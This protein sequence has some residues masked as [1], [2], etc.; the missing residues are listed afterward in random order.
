VETPGLILVP[1]LLFAVTL[2]IGLEMTR[3]DLSATLSHRGLL[4]RTLL[5]NLILVPALG[6]AITR[7]LSVPKD[8]TVGL[9]LVSTAPGGL[10]A[11]SLGRAWCGDPTVAAGMSGI[12]SGTAILVTPVLANLVLPADSPVVLA[13]APMVASL[14]LFLWPSLLLGC[15]IR[16]WWA[17]D[18][19]KLTRN[20]RRIARLCFAAT[21]L[22]VVA[23]KA[24][25][26]RRIDGN[27]VAA[28][29]LLALGAAAIGWM[30][31][32]PDRGIRAV[33]ARST[34]MRN[35]PL[36]LLIALKGFPESDVALA[37]ITFSVLAL[38]SDLLWH[39]IESRWEP[40]PA[41]AS[42]SRAR[43]QRP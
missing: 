37:V 8:V 24:P 28:L 16:H 35:I 41:G 20:V 36:S 11:L 3:G 9:L 29:A 1:L 21:I 40:W 38:L 12:L 34:G 25:A 17:D 33:L 7:L 13:T 6:I 26:I 14:A 39:D 32:G 42:T 30:L 27:A 15:V 22:L 5:A 10:S 4:G 23:T 18:A 43:P 31:G 2:S 19:P